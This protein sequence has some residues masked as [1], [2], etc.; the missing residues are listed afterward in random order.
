MKWLIW[1]TLPIVALI[2]VIA[3]YAAPH[4]SAVKFEYEKLPVLGKTDAPV[5]I[6]E[7]GDYKCPT[8]KYF[9]QKIEPQIKKDFI[10]T[11][12]AALY[13]MNF[14]FIGPDSNTAALAAQAVYHQNNDAFWTYY[15]AL[16]KNQGDEKVQ[17]ATPQ[18]LTS[19]AQK[20]NVK[21]DTAKLQQ[22][23]TAKT[24]QKEVDTHNAFAKDIRL[25][26]TPTIFI[27]GKKFDKPYDYSAL[28]RA[29]ASAQ[30]GGK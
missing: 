5:K 17:W 21:V 15:D 13:F 23:I 9:A 6:V 30:K 29:I 25:N 26:E 3:I 4:G 19:L 11:G 12:I 24:Y 8:C 1:A 7:F 28:K 14:T 20:E 27:N 10:D 22:D 16:Y 2:I 18:Y